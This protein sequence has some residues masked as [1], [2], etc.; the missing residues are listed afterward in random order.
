M[1]TDVRIKTAVET[2]MHAIGAPSVPLAAIRTKMPKAALHLEQP[3]PR[4]RF[5]AAAAVAAAVVLSVLPLVSPAVM[6][7]LEV[8]YR[9][10]L[11]ALG[12]IAPPP[13]PKTL[14][15]RL[16]SQTVTLAQAQS[17][18]SFT[19][20]PPSGLPKDVVS[21]KIVVTPTGIL[22]TRT[23]SWSVGPA[24]V[25]FR[26]RRA[27]G[28]EF[29]LIADRYDARGERPGKY[30]FE[31]G[32]VGPNG[33]PILIKHRQF[34]WRNGD[35]QMLATQGRELRTP[36]ILAIQSAMRGTPVTMRALHSPD[37]SS[38]RTLRVVRP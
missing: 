3:R 5:A 22:N 34:A 32:G 30:L 2:M 13:A 38:T 11:R 23:H 27:N 18:V 21:S 36:E 19:I 12:G 28:A 37:A 8:R 26:Y 24:E 15:S 35:Q 33:H 25:T 10:A 6:Q 31:T 14:I 20:V 16:E 9:A 7:G 1:P 29:A 17:R 4:G